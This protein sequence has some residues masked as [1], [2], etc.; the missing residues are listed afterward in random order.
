MTRGRCLVRPARSK[1]SSEHDARVVRGKPAQM[2]DV[3]AGV[4]AFADNRQPEG[5]SNW[6][7][8]CD[9]VF[10]ALFRH[11]AAHEHH[12]TVGFQT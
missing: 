5:S 4:S 3:T 7:K 6:S 1:Q 11:Q 10:H 8:R 12:I 2:I 9:Q